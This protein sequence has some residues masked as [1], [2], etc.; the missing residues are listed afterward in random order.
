MYDASMIT[1][2]DTSMLRKT[3]IAFTAIA[4]LGATATAAS[5]HGWGF[6]RHFGFYGGPSYVVTDCYWVKRYTPFGV[7]FVKVCGY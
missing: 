6:H 4:A 3:M 2:G 5:A 7:R 1:R